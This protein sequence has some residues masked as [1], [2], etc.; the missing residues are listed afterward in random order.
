MQLKT[1]NEGFQQRATNAPSPAGHGYAPG[2]SG[3][4][5][6]P[7]LLASWDY[8]VSALWRPCEKARISP[9]IGVGESFCLAVAIPRPEIAFQSWCN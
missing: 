1:F 4:I 7:I 8:D 6:R 9:E 3:S 2:V 5:A